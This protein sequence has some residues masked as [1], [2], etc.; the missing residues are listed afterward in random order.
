MQDLETI[1]DLYGRVEELDIDEEFTKHMADETRQYSR[2]MV[3]VKEIREAHTQAPEYFENVGE[4][5]RAPVILVGPT[6][7]GRMIVMPIEPTHTI[8]IWH[9]VTAFEANTHH[10]ERYMERHI[11]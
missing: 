3:S 2:H 10:I 5:L 4:N 11:S 6:N 9:P 1:F 8:G 7:T